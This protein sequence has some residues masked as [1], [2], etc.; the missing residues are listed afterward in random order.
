MIANAFRP[1]SGAA[2]FIAW[3]SLANALLYH[4]PIV[5]F[6]IRNLGLASVTGVATLLTLALVVLAITA[7]AL[8]LLALISHRVLKPFCMLM[9]V[10]N[11]VALYFVVTY[12]VILDKAMMGNVLGTDIAESAELF[13]PSL[14]AYVAL[15]GVAPCWLLA[16]VQ[17]R[18]AP[19][20]HLAAGAGAVLLATL[21]WGYLASPTWLWFDHNAKKLGGLVLPWSYLVNTTRS[22]LPRLWAPAQVLLPPATF[23]SDEPAVVV[24]V[25]GEAARRRNFQLY[26]YGR[27]TNPLLSQAGVVA[28]PNAAAC[29]TYTTASLRC[30]LS[31]VDSGSEFARRYEPLPS[32]LQR[33]GVDVI[34][35]TR[36]WGEPAMQVQSFERGRELR[37]GCTG[38]GCE[39]DEVLLTGLEQR[40]RASKSPRVF[41]VLHQS[42]SHG[43][44][45]SKKY[46]PRLEAFT[47]VCRSVELS[48]CT[49]QE[50]V[51]AYDN[52]IRYTDEFLS[53]VIAL[54]KRLEHTPSLMI[55]VADHGE[56][57]GE[58]GLYLHGTPLS[59]APDVQKEIPFILWM[60]PEFAS[61]RGVDP[62]Q[63]LSRASHDQH[64]I[65][66]TVMGAFALRS[67]AYRG[68][69]DLFAA[70]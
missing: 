24:L 21:I 31:H 22:Q 17:I 7:V 13:H 46:P 2:G 8:G 56:S 3:T 14:L 20:R 68:E 1:N 5:L 15:L 48:Q 50:L 4:A 61:A 51:N 28:L 65:F 52:T 26:G 43:P 62:R 33:H 12:G 29:S 37:A 25:I 57:L 60:S 67:D 10:G 19:R 40:I 45:Y 64:E 23:T 44:A 58:Y 32:Y 16:R 41:V 39:F 35:R 54:L 9:A 27:P 69:Y 47:P 30:I 18:P 42:G 11:S 66:H 59:I 38:D 49:S 63:L 36:N 6:A 53:Q 70:P 34:W 55:Y